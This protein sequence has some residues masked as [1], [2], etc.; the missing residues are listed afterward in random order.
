MPQDLWGQRLSPRRKKK[1]IPLTAA[2][3]YSIT[4]TNEECQLM[5]H[6]ISREFDL[7]GCNICITC[8]IKIYC[9]V[10]ITTH[11]Q[12]DNAITIL[13]ERHEESQVRP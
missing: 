3:P 13:C 4:G 7:A 1:V 11:P 6:T 10:C 9:P 2:I 5:G 12:D 8:G